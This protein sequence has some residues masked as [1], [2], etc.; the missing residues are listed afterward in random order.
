MS[1]SVTTIGEYNKAQKMALR[2]YQSCA[3]KGEHPY[4]P[5]LDDILSHVDIVGEVNVGLVDI[6][7]DRVVGTSTQGRT[8]AFAGNFMPLLDYNTEF[9][10]KWMNLYDSHIEEGIRD[11]IQVYEYM[12]RFY[13]V[14]GNK[15][16][17]VLKFSEAV[18]VPAIVTRKVPK[19]TDD[20][21]NKIYFE[22][23]DFYNVTG[24]NY[25]WFSKVGSFEK[26]MVYTG[27]KTD[28]KWDEEK[29]KDFN[30]A[31]LAFS[32]AFK[33]KG[34][35]K[36]PITT[37][38]ALLSFLDIYS[39][40]EFLKMT[41]EDFKEE[42]PKLWK[43]FL[44]DAAGEHIDLLMDPSEEPK[45]KI[46]SYILPT[47]AKKVKV[48]F[49]YDKL[50]EE[51]EWIYSH[52][53]G[54]IYLQENFSDIFDISAVSNVGIGDEA[55]NKIEELIKSGNNIIFTTTPQL[56]QICM[57]MAIKYPEVKIFNCSLNTS[58]QY[59]RTYSARMY[60]AKFLTGVIAGAMAES[61]K[62]GYVADY[63]IYGNIA[64][65]NAF[66]LGAKFVNPRATVYL[67]W[68]TEKNM[69][70][71]KYFRDNGIS[72]VSDQDMI[73]PNKASR[74][75]GLYNCNDGTTYNLA[76]PVYHW[77]IFYEKLIK[78]II[79]G[80]FK[81]ETQDNKALNYWWGMSAGVI[82]LICSKT[83]PAETRKLVELLKKMICS[84]EFNPFSGIINSQTGVIQ[85]NEDD[86]MT[87]EEIMKIDWLASN[88]VGRIP[89]IDE[90]EDDAKLTVV[91]KGVENN[92]KAYME[93]L[94]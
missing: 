76:M 69:D 16:V 91:L 35:S 22:F 50:P 9:G 27:T 77:G 19:K 24:V 74:Q 11:P 41:E 73:T 38:D 72:Y 80:S 26:L 8:Q 61:D 83:V 28:K 14:E 47:S 68:S 32:N 12:N 51:S 7:L 18:S 65:I 71:D 42:L 44:L 2:R 66:A 45:K 82:E 23:L 15:R 21:E 36:L 17:S 59:I 75:F 48:A 5:V 57:K 37:G 3:S 84:G 13:V 94:E 63:P 56:L 93:G 46:L 43:E 78:S 90:L 88:I 81:E 10:A 86:C 62:I 25:L 55:E 53:L 79:S 67:G 40:D 20:I 29:K 4:L 52:D 92:L 58:H 30:S 6:P 1:M 33:A 70:V 49:V 31:H 54:R 89:R 85:E 87:P 60:E 64:N 34:G 39:Y